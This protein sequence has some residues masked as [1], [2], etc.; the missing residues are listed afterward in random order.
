MTVCIGSISNSNVIVAADRMVTLQLPPTEFE[1]TG[2]KIDA[3][4]D[5][6]LFLTAGQVLPASEIFQRSKARLA[7]TQVVG[8]EDVV[9]L[10]A[11]VYKKYRLEVVENVWLKPRALSL[12][13]FYKEGKSMGIPKELALALDRDM[14][15]FNLGVELIIAGVDIMGGHLYSVQNPGIYNCHDKIGYAAIGSGAMHATSSFIVSKY[16]VKFP[17]N[18]SIYCTFEAKFAAE[19]AP[20]VG[21]D[22]DMGTITK[23]GTKFFDGK[24]IS[25]LRE[26]CSKII[27]AKNS[28][29]ANLIKNLPFE[30][31]LIDVREQ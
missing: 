21:S 3:L 6:V 9:K 10:V 25:I 13:S 16:S 18:E 27:Q 7:S 22:T 1:H 5:K 30:K 12:D 23:L 14:V 26:T 11:D 24:E 20:G 29:D 8:V 31:E 15:Q 4:T 17:F 19:R 2:S 28:S